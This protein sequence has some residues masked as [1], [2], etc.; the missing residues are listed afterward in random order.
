MR[1]LTKEEAC[2]ELGMS[3]STLDR[4][5][6]AGQ[7]MVTREPHGQRH[8]VYVVVEDNSSATNGAINALTDMESS[9]TQLAVARERVRCLEQLVDFLK[10]ELGIAQERNAELLTG[11]SAARETLTTQQRRYK[12]WRF[13]AKERRRV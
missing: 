1:L 6:S 9:N 8:R 2:R 4:R 3:L 7:L 5:I 11:L 13:W 12:W 10:G